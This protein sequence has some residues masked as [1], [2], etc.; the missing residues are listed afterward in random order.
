[1]RPQK[2][3]GRQLEE[4]AKAVGGGYCR[5]QMPLKLALAVRETVAGHKLP[6]PFQCLGYAR[7]NSENSCNGH[8][9]TC[10]QLL[11]LLAARQV[12]PVFKVFRVFEVL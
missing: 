1:M 7:R 5:L 2:R 9:W 12:L 6:P 3:V 4:V 11:L 8:T 10:E